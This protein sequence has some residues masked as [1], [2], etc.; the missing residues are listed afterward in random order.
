MKGLLR[1]LEDDPR[2]TK[3]GRLLPTSLDELPVLQCKLIGDMSLI[4]TRP[5]TES[6]FKAYSA[7]S[8]HIT[9]LW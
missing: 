8:H 4:G 1:L 6:E 9:G 3:I 7:G 2:I 5:P